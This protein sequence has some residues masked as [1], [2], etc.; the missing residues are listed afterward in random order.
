[1]LSLTTG[2]LSCVFRL[3][4]HPNCDLIAPGP[5]SRLRRGELC[6][7][8]HA[9]GLHT[10]DSQ[11]DASLTPVNWVCL[12]NQVAAFWLFMSAGALH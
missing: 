5:E 10:A 12:N 1:M 7:L 4:I 6:M 8:R 9:S 3:A 11:R 2:K